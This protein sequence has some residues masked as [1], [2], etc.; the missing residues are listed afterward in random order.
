MLIRA[1]PALNTRHRYYHVELKSLSKFNGTTTDDWDQDLSDEERK[2]LRSVNFPVEFEDIVCGLGVSYGRPT[3]GTKVDMRKVKLHT[4]RPRITMKF[5]EL[6]N[7]E[8]ELLEDKSQPILDPRKMQIRLTVFLTTHATA[9]MSSL[10][11]LLLKSQE[12]PNGVPQ[13]LVKEEKKDH[14]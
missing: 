3:Y 6:V 1:F 13:S 10:W 11:K 5:I 8:D 14:D 2:L 4:M 12:S 9:F 7:F